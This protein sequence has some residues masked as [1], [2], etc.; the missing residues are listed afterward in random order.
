MNATTMRKTLLIFF[1]AFASTATHGQLSTD[2]STQGLLKLSKSYFRS[3]PFK[4]EFSGFLQHLINDPAIK[5]KNI[6]KRT[7][8]SLYAFDGVF[9]NYNPFFFKPKRLEVTLEEVAV[10]YTMDSTSTDT[11]FVYQLLAY[12]DNNAKAEA[13]IR[14]EFEKIHRQNRSR[15][16]DNDYKETQQGASPA[17]LHNYFVPLHLLAPASIILSKTADTKEWQLNITLRF[18]RNGNSVILPAPLQRL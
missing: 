15:F 1:I 6:H 4:G 10:Q 2:P 18:K 14:K 12:A 17:I 9:T 3:D 7:D 8:T 16:F 11:I 13:E 5:E